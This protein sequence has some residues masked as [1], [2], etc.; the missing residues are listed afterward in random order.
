MTQVELA[1]LLKGAEMA[2]AQAVAEA[3]RAYWQE[4]TSPPNVKALELGMAVAWEARAG[5]LG[6]LVGKRLKLTWHQ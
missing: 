6:R 5:D 4:S 3:A 2:H 1:N